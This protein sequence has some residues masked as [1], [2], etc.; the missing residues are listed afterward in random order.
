[1]TRD[2]STEACILAAEDNAANRQVLKIITSKLGYDIDL[3]ED[4]AKALAAAKVKPYALILMD[5]HMPVMDG[6]EAT[7]AIRAL[8]GDHGDMP[9]I[10]VTADARPGV[11][12]RVLN[13]GM[14][15]YIAKPINVSLLANAIHKWLGEKH[16]PVAD[17]G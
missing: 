14:D 11:H 2:A 15:D 6:Y 16:M 4:G 9:I 12:E 1:M 10:A 7:Q 3:A 5:L 13:S 17:V 8:P